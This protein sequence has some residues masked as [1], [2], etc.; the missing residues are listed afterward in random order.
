[1]GNKIPNEEMHRKI[2]IVLVFIA[3]HSHAQHFVALKDSRLVD[4]AGNPI[5]LNGVNLGGWLLWEGWIWGDGFASETSLQKNIEKQTSPAFAQLFKDSIHQSFIRRTDLQKIAGAGFNCVRVPFNHS[6]LDNGRYDDRLDFG[7]LDSVVAWCKALHL[8]VVLDMHAL[9]G[10]Q[11]GLFIADPDRDGLWGNEKNKSWAVRLWY[12]IAKRYAREPSIAGY[13][14]INEPSTGKKVELLDLY[15]RL[16][17]TIRTVDQ[18]HLLIIEGNNFARDFD[19]FDRKFDDNQIFS[20]HYYPWLRGNAG[21][22]R[23]VRDYAEVGKRL[24]TPM[25]CGEWGEDNYK[26]LEK[27]HGLLNSPEYNFCGTAFWTWKKANSNFHPALNGFDPPAGLN[28]V[29]NGS[30]PGSGRAEDQL[31]DLISH[32]RQATPNG[33]LLAL[34]TKGL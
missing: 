2:F 32:A 9:P 18:Q 10:G 31:L 27:I 34:L 3:L 24:G 15:R 12:E 29:L 8:Y 14:L 5:K 4:G 13:D 7:V 17:D 22:E 20:F 30:K 28:K 16:V 25:W 23:V 6:L 11:S 19:W 21:K 26:N 1:M 33:Q